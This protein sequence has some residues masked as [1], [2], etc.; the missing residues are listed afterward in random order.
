MSGVFVH[1]LAVLCA[2]SVTDALAL[3][4]E[5]VTCPQGALR[6]NTTHATVWVGSSTH[7]IEQHPDI[8]PA[9]HLN[10]GALFVVDTTPGQTATLFVC[11]VADAGSEWNLSSELDPPTWNIIWSNSRRGLTCFFML[12]QRHIWA[13]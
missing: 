6:L 8:V 10:G 12:A 9:Q 7:H 2:A 5:N 1:F 13:C 4:D 11:V 3:T